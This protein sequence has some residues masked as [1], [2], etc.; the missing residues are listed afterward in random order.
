MK[1]LSIIIPV[2]NEERF[3]SQLLEKVSKLDFS[4]LGYEKEMI[5][6]NDGSKDRSHDLI[7][8]F[9]EQYDGKSSY[10]Q[11]TNHGK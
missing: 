9:I 5:I 8:E 3:V 7:Q 2:Y 1:L 11:H 10:V 6:V 4:H